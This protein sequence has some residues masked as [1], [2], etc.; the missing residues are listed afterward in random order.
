MSEAE[1]ELIKSTLRGIIRVILLWLLSRRKMSGYAVTKEV[2]RLTGRTFHSGIIYPL[3]YELE[4]KGLITG[5][6]VKKGRKQIKYYYLTE[7]G[8]NLLNSL[9]E[10]FK[11]PIK[12]VL[13]DLIG[14][15][16]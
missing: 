10:L 8:K 1:K 2:K 16:L 6:W 15:E 4:E 3:L 14:E 13:K 7:D 5:E 9:R 11:M 12:E